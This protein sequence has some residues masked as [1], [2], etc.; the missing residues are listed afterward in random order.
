MRSSSVAPIPAAHTTHRPH[1]DGAHTQCVCT[2]ARLPIAGRH[3]PPQTAPYRHQRRRPSA[4]TRTAQE[5][6]FALAPRTNPH[7]RSV[8]ALVVFSC[9]TPF[10]LS[11]RL[12]FPC[13]VRRTYRPQTSQRLQP[14][15]RRCRCRGQT[16]SP[17]RGTAADPTTW[18][19]A[20]TWAWTLRTLAMNGVRE[21]GSALR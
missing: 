3:V 9:V 15:G 11:V 12:T 8:P 18:Q 16:S 1:G 13:G 20:A 7:G 21:I 4:P 19:C 17:T 5:A 2:R 10:P 6:V 14:H